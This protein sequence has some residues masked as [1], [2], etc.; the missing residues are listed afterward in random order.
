MHM[1]KKKLLSLSIVVIMLAILSFSSLAWF[2]DA[3]EVTNEFLIA[4]SE[5][6]PD[7]IFSVDV[8]ED[9]DD[10]GDPDKDQDGNTY[11]DIL[12]G[13]RYYKQ[14]YVENTGAYDQ[15]IRV[16]VTVTNADA[17]IAALGNG[18]DLG[19]MFEGHDEALWTRYE[20]GVYDGNENTY[21]M[22]FYLNKILEPDATEYLFTHVVIP[23]QLTQNDMAFIGGA[24]ELKIVAEAVQ[25]ENLG[26]GVD[27][28]YEAFQVLESSGQEIDQI[29]P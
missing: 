22:T 11:E 20:A 3:D 19:T 18:Y 10:D 24:F 7:K 26:D 25:T 12:P 4:D 17:W 8:W 6:E 9:V 13:G 15:F 29:K 21:T 27:T 16:K 23:G 28:A 1:N 2:S 5:S 14:P